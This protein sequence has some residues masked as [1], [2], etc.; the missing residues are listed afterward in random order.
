[1]GITSL[2]VIS[3][4]RT[5]LNSIAE[6]P[7]KKLDGRYLYFD[8]INDS[9]SDITDAV[10]LKEDRI[11]T[12]AIWDTPE[13]KNEECLDFESDPTLQV[14]GE[15]FIDE[16]VWG[17]D[18]RGVNN[19]ITKRNRSFYQ[20]FNC[21]TEVISIEPLGYNTSVRLSNIQDSPLYQ[22]DP[23]DYELNKDGTSKFYF[24]PNPESGWFRCVTDCDFERFNILNTDYD[25][26][27]TTALSHADSYGWR[28]V[29]NA[30]YNGIE[31]NF[32]PNGVTNWWDSVLGVGNNL[33]IRFV[34]EDGTPLPL[35]AW[36]P[37][38]NLDSGLGKKSAFGST[39]N[40][41]KVEAR[42]I[43]PPEGYCG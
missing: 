6:F 17:D 18:W 31:F 12:I 5:D 39:V 26:N 37:V 38:C 35:S 16:T 2:Y 3:D 19:L 27:K 11:V 4:N 13:S 29:L 15:S 1:M 7:G 9:F 30:K 23:I 24:S 22:T 41:Y 28:K 33:K 21:T 25:P 34:Q 42:Y 8:T 36:Y 32:Y 43:K 10:D 14:F 20:L 40:V